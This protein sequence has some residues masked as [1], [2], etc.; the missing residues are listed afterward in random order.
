M[1]FEL[2][3]AN[4]PNKRNIYYDSSM[5]HLWLIYNSSMTHLWL[6]YDLSMTHLWLIYVPSMSHLWLIYDSSMTHLWLIND[7]SSEIITYYFHFENCSTTMTT[8][9]FRRYP[10]A[11]PPG[12]RRSSGRWE[13]TLRSTLRKW[14]Y[15]STLGILTLSESN[16]SHYHN[17]CTF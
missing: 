8:W 15:H 5:T 9:S 4:D 3:N 11:A 12:R 17:I 16:E 6:I 7:S 14:P 13:T 10:K 2:F 1:L